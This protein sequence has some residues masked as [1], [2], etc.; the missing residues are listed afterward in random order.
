[1]FFFQ[2]I[3]DQPSRNVNPYMF[4]YFVL[5]IVFGV[6]I[7]GNLVI[8]ILLKQIQHVGSLAVALNSSAGQKKRSGQEH[9]QNENE[10]QS[11]DAANPER[12]TYIRNFPI[13]FFKLCITFTVRNYIVLRIKI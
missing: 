8:G 12:V 9:R 11:N 5:F 4:I 1:M 6:F 7:C 2:Q 13:I 3:D 10:L